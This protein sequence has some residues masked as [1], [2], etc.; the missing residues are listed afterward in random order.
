[1]VPYVNYPIRPF[2]H[3]FLLVVEDLSLRLARHFAFF[4]GKINA[5]TMASW[6][7]LIMLSVNFTLMRMLM[8]SMAVGWVAVFLNAASQGSRIGTTADRVAADFVISMAYI[9]GYIILSL[10][11]YW[12]AYTAARFVNPFG[13]LLMTIL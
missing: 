9:P 2:L 8:V 13:T 10:V 7:C 11:I 5:S 3:F 6:L 12:I 4:K 1:M